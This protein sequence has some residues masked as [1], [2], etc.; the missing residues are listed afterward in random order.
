MLE[1]TAF[2]SFMQR[3]RGGDEQAAAELVR[4]YEPFIWREVRM[5]LEDQHLRRLFDSL[6]ISQSVF[7]SFFV[8]SSMGQYDLERPD[9]LLNLLVAMTRN[10]LASAARQQNRQRRDQRRTTGADAEVLGQVADPRPSGEEVLANAEL[11]Q[12]LR[13][14]LSEEERR[15]ADLRAAGCSWETIATEQGGT[16][17]ARRMQLTRAIDRVARELGADLADA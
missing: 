14:L 7:L 2:A 15:L 10:K 12:R 5:H 9:Q 6:D 1:R 8:R 13:G 4:H 16:A 11:L 17:K 3:L